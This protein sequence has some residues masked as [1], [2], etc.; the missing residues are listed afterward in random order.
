M[1]DNIGALWKPASDNPK[2]PLAKGKITV[3]GQDIAI[4]IWP[5]RWKAQDLADG[6]EGAERKPD[7]FIQLDKPRSSS[8][9]VL[10]GG[11]GKPKEA[12]G[13][14]DDIPPF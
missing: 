4:V 14:Q 2:A 8:G 1:Q 9:N 3:N 11:Y 6:K 7:Y 5:N 13:F 12:D 10:L